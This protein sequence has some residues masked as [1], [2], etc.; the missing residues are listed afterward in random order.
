[1]E[2]LTIGINVLSRSLATPTTTSAVDPVIKSRPLTHV[3]LNDRA[4]HITE[5]TSDY[6]SA[7]SLCSTMSISSQLP[8]ASHIS[9]SSSRDELIDLN[10]T[11]ADSVHVY[12]KTPITSLQSTPAPCKLTPDIWNPCISPINPLNSNFHY[13][14]ADSLNLDE[15]ILQKSILNIVS[16]PLKL[17]HIYYYHNFNSSY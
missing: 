4:N 3:N 1:M 7:S 12:Y 11:S 10:M 16:S 5:V 17:Q 9:S 8:S 14:E 13:Q 15:T 6:I 2:R